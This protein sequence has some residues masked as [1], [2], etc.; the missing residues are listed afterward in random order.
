M[1]YQDQ[2]SMNGTEAYVESADAVARRIRAAKIKEQNAKAARKGGSG[3]SKVWY[4][5]PE[6]RQD[7]GVGRLVVRTQH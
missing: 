1:G 7:T 4:E 5:T 3:R 2:K 6:H